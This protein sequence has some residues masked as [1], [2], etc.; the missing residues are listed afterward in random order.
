MCVY[1]YTHTSL[2]IINNKYI[3][4]YIF[5]ISYILGLIDKIG[6]D[7]NHMLSY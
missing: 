4:I 3:Y 6:T 1:I 7:L 5:C 2:N